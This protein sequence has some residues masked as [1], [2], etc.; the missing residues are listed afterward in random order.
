M[1]Y[2]HRQIP[3]IHKN[4]IILVPIV[5]IICFSCYRDAIDLNLEDLG[6]QT[7]IEANISDRS[8][9]Y[10]VRISK[11][12]GFNQLSN[13]QQVAGA[14]VFISDNQGNSEMLREIE[15]GLYETQSL[16]GKSGRIYM[17]SVLAEGKEFTASSKMP[18][19]IEFDFIS[20]QNHGWDYTFICAFT[21]RQGVDDFCRIKVFKN[22]ELVYRYLYQGR[23]S[24]GEQIILDDFDVSFTENENVQ[25]QLLT[26]NQEM[27]EYLIMLNP[28]EGGGDYNPEMP[29]FFPV[30]PANPK[31]NIDNNAL[32]YFSAHTVRIYN[33]S[34]VN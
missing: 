8:G 6:P 3:A 30:S 4:L 33:L 34:P 2:N 5:F 18:E 11:T 12:G 9:P 27:Y 24:D 25:I 1:K 17:L 20:L 21:D 26:I 28:D 7:V 19:A 22:G 13:F 32:G 23:Y 14:E 31:T 15:A 29:E 16:Q 10:Q